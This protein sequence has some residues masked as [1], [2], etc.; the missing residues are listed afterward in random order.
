MSCI[1]VRRLKNAITGAPAVTTPAVQNAV[2]AVHATLK[3]A[4]SKLNDG[5][6]KRIWSSPASSLTEILDPRGASKLS[7]FTWNRNCNWCDTPPKPS[8]ITMYKKP[9]KQ[10]SP[11]ANCG[12]VRVLR[13]MSPENIAVSGPL[14]WCLSKLCHGRTKLSTKN[15]VLL[16]NPNVYLQNIGPFKYLG[17]KV[18]TSS[19]NKEPYQVHPSTNYIKLQG[20][21]APQVVQL[22][23]EAHLWGNSMLRPQSWN[24]LQ[25]QAPT[26][27]VTSGATKSPCFKRS[28]FSSHWWQLEK[29]RMET[30]KTSKNHNK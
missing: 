29:W 18:V 6:G 24:D 20:T 13:H 15:A 7:N 28:D 9:I 8:Y 1:P 30:G 2:K 11:L 26:N 17:I 22:I 5:G 12:W 10:G 23:F 19:S 3:V 16:P 25:A 4:I 14:A 21:A 27:V